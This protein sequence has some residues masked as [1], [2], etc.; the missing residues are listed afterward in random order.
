MW[1]RVGE[2]FYQAMFVV[3]GLIGAWWLT[4]DVLL[5]EWRLAAEAA[6]FSQATCR[7]V[8]G[9]VEQRPGLAE[10]E[11]CP[12]LQ[13]EYTP[14][15]VEAQRRVW[16][17]HGV[18]RDT[19]S[20][21]EAYAALERYVLGEERPCWYDPA[22]PERV[23]LSVRR[24]W[25][26]W[27]VLSIPVSLIVSGVLGLSRSVST[28]GASPERRAAQRQRG[29][30]A[31]SLDDALSRPVSA[32]GLP[33]VEPIEESPGVV[34]AYRLPGDSTD[35]WRVAGAATLCVAWNALAALLVYHL[36]SG[37]LPVAGRLGVVAAAV[38][39]LT[40]IGVRL[41]LAVWREARGVGAAGSTR[42]E[43]DRTPLRV[44]D[45]AE[46]ILIQTG[47]TRFRAV[48]VSLVCEEVAIYRQGT[49]AR[50]ATAEVRRVELLRER[51][52]KLDAGEPL[53]RDFQVEIPD[54]GP[55]SFTSP[56]NEVRWLLETRLTPA[57]RAEVRRRF[58]LCVHPSQTPPAADVATAAYSAGAQPTVGQP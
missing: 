44:G 13:V 34:R 21:D 24:R 43:L 26:P 37:S 52:V 32:S 42:I 30:D 4:S 56:H 31:G 7:V 3:A 23:L 8:G 11:Y 27:L 14:E 36:V 29:I 10:D 18:G 2:A 19:P 5:P 51:N 28:A 33:A 39:P 6:D 46:A 55:H 17:R 49:D 20:R 50:T 16:T 53:R 47:Q 9:R 48:V 40:L 58:P 25:W 15:G 12:T 41:T 57:G 1:A 35:S 38:A 45:V 54:E 22:D